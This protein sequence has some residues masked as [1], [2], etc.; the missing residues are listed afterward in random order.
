MLVGVSAGGWGSLAAA[1][2]GLDGLIGVVNFAGGR[3]S[4]GPNSVCSP[5][6]LVEAA[7]RFGRSSRVPELWI[8]AEND[9][10]FGPDLAARM[11]AAFTEA[12]G[13]AQLIQAPAFSDDGHRYFPRG[14]ENWMPL[15][16]P[17]LRQVGALR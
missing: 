16:Q 8:Y 11:H 9:M 3:G 5:D 15:I 2:Q 7:G 6:R 12:G 4:R 10:F 14:T 17:F 13:R 1:S